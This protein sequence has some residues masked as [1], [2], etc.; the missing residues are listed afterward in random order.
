MK[1]PGPVG[2][3]VLL[4]LAFPFVIEL[5]TVLAWLGVDLASTVYYPA[6][7]VV[8]GAVVVA[9][10]VLPEDEPGNPSEGAADSPR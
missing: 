5:R 1:R 4:V 2:I 7:T 9:L 6:A 10:L 8:V 3:V